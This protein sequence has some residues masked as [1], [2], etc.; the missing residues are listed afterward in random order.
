MTEQTRRE[1]GRAAA[2][3][4]VDEL[5][6]YERLADT[7]V[8]EA[9]ISL[10]VALAERA[11]ARRAAKSE[12]MKWRGYALAPLVWAED[13]GKVSAPDAEDIADAGGEAD[14]RVTFAD[15]WPEKAEGPVPVP[16]KA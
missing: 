7:A 6:A 8:F 10:N 13:A 1:K 3:E 9:R 4:L 12:W 16:I 15:E 5:L 14:D 2:Q 11:T